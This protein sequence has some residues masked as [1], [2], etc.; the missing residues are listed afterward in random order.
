[1]DTYLTLHEKGT[2]ARP[3]IITCEVI[4]T[5]SFNDQPTSSFESL[6]RRKLPMQLIDA[7]EH[8]SRISPAGIIASY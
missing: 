4:F 7:L 3:N 5:N 8:D 6:L 1:M 2:I